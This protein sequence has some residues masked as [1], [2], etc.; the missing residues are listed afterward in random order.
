MV[1]LVWALA[2]RRLEHLLRHLLLV[3]S[4]QTQGVQNSL[5]AKVLVL[6]VRVLKLLPTLTLLL[7]PEQVLPT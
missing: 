5:R 6:V 4:L 7:K 3:L 2:F 1:A